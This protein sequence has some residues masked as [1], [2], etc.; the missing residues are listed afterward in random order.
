ALKKRSEETTTLIITHRIA[1]AKDADLIIVL[2][3]GTISEQG[4][5]EQLIA[6]KGLYQRVYEIQT[7]L[8]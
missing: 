1:T 2:E 5:H 6:R 7:K 8:Q 4:T 3:N